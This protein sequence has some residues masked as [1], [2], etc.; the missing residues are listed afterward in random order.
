[1]PDDGDGSHCP[2]FVSLGRTSVW[3]ERYFCEVEEIATTE[4]E[5]DDGERYKHFLLSTIPLR[6]PSVK[7][8]YLVTCRLEKYRTLTKKWLFAHEV[9]FDNLIM[10]DLPNKEARQASGGH[11]LFKADVYKSTNAR[12]FIE[13]NN[14]QANEIAKISNKPVLCIDTQQMVYPSFAEYA[15]RKIYRDPFSVYRR[16]KIFINWFNRHLFD[17]SPPNS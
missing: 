5:N 7:I 3:R 6:I 13:S 1:M 9:E 4:E 15:V 2:S 14:K 17:I 8:K 10:M 12:L 16:M 11:A